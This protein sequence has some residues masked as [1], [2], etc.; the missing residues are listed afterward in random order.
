MTLSVKNIDGV[1]IMKK[2]KRIIQVICLALS[3]VLLVGVVFMKN[4]DEVN[5]NDEDVALSGTMGN[6]VNTQHV[7]EQVIPD[8]YN[9]GVTGELIP[10]TS[11]CYISG[12]KF[13]TTGVSDRKLDLYYQKSEVPSTIIVENYD[14]SSGDFKFYNADLIEK[15]VK[16][17]YKNCKFQSYTIDGI[18][19]VYHQFENCTFTHFGGGNATFL[20]CY[21]GGGTD[22]DGI[23]P[24][25]NCS[26][27]NCMIADLIQRAD[28]AG[29]KHV[30]GFQIF[31]DNS[32]LDNTD[33]KLSNCRFEMPFL[34][35][36][37]PSGAMN[38]PLS[39]IMRYSDA[40]NISFD[41]CYVN[42]GLYYALMVLA[43]ENNVT[44]LSFSNIHLG[45]S[46]KSLYT[47]DPA[48]ESLIQ[49][50]VSATDALYVA[51]V[52]KLS[53]GIHL[54]V[55]NDTAIERTLAVVTA[56]GTKEYT[57]PACP[58]GINL[59]MDSTT[60]EDCPFDIDITIPDAEWVVCYDITSGVKQIRFVNWT[61]DDVY[62]DTNTFSAK[63]TQKLT[64]TVNASGASNTD[65]VTKSDVTL[66]VK[67]EQEGVCGK[68]AEFVYGD[69]VLMIMGS[70][71]TDNYHSGKRAPWY[72]YRNDIIEVVVQ[73]GIT[74]IGNQMFAECKN[75]QKVIL[76]EGVLSI[77][78]NV[79]K[80][81]TSLEYIYIPKS[82]VS[83][84]QRS[85]TADLK[86][87]EY[88]G[89]IDE[90]NQITFGNYNTAILNADIIYAEDE[91]IL[92][93]GQCG[94]HVQWTFSSKGELVLTGEGATFDYHSGKTA[95][96]FTY[97]ADIQ[98]IIIKEGITAIGNY[99][100][101][102]CK[103]V[104]DIVLPNSVTKVG[105]NSFSR[106]KGLTEISF[107]D[108]LVSIGKNAFA[109]TSLSV[110]NYD[111]TEENWSTIS[112]NTLNNVEVVYCR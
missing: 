64:S 106:C 108:S 54:S 21:F 16:V 50:G 11:D 69:G 34:P 99:M 14:F 30:D 22:G 35:M 83:I 10:V 77:G 45:G 65:V 48:F 96:W 2:N 51:S 4:D 52:R 78:T 92:Q 71:A 73:E 57:I 80:K 32:G 111:G 25:V 40:N 86:T 87:V 107:S 70:G 53:D 101:R 60:Y 95:P 15:T 7:D 91:I 20:S 55:T 36:S 68:N 85:F 33:I 3:M 19:K 81:C 89:S 56:K 98:K 90:W 110:V 9:T 102:D 109:G 58:K 23:N 104:T 41:D 47:C 63:E 103:N 26:F 74:G 79:F 112:G 49:S 24:M 38:C 6:L 88:G 18:G 37:T 94:N 46:S 59:S 62:V 66:E 100:F 44:N 84:G 1:K 97:A 75:L 28:V 105:I 5:I 29:S 17:I 31:G 42:G 82:I 76:S 12:V 39:I 8:K 93:S 67:A 72:E 13:G 43:N 61:N 27:T